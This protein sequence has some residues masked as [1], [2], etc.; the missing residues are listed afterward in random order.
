MCD[1][2]GLAD[3]EDSFMEGLKLKIHGFPLGVL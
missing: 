2:L 1:I 3:M